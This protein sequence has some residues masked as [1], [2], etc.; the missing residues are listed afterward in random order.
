MRSLRVKILTT[1]ATLILASQISTVTAVLVTAN[2]DVSAR[3]ETNLLAGADLLSTTID[4]RAD[5]LAATV[6]ALASDFGFKQAVGTGETETVRSALQNHAERANADIAFIVDRNNRLLVTGVGNN[7]P[8]NMNEAEIARHGYTNSGRRVY[9]T[10]NA[11]YEILTVPVKAPLPIA[12]LSMGFKLDDAFARHLQKLTGLEVTLLGNSDAGQNVIAASNSKYSKSELLRAAQLIAGNTTTDTVDIDGHQHLA[13][14]H[15]FLDAHSEVGLLITKP[16]ADA[17]APYEL[18]KKASFALGALPLL[19]ALLGAVLLSRALTHPINRLMAAARRIQAGEYDVPVE[20]RSGDELREFGGAFNAMQSEISAREKRIVHQARHDTVTGLY[21]STYA[22]ELLSA[23][24]EAAKE[25]GNTVG[26]MV[27]GLGALDEI[28]SSLGHDLAS[29]YL[30]TIADRLQRF[31]GHDHILARMENDNFLIALTEH[32]SLR[33]RTVAE[34]LIAQLGTALKLESIKVNIKPAVGMALF[35]E[36]SSNADELLLR[37]TIARNEARLTGRS[38]RFYRKGDQEKRL[39]NMNLLQDLGRAT[40][41]NELQL[42]YQPKITLEDESVC[43]AEALVRWRHPD[44]G[45]L[46]PNEF[47]PL[48]E[49]SGNALILTRWVIGEACRQLAE[50]DR[51]GLNLNIAI[52]LSATDLLHDSLPW[53][54]MDAVKEH[55]LDPRNLIME[56]TEEAMV[57]DFQKANSTLERMHDLGLTIS[58]DD[59]GT[60]YSSLAQLKNLPAQELKI[61]R[62]FIAGVPADRADTAIVSAAINLA[63]ELGLKIVAEGVSDG[64]ALRWLRQHSVDRAQGF[65]WSK[66]LSANQF[67][68]WLGSFT[69][70]KTV[71]VKPLKL[72]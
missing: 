48:I 15:T 52:N 71:Q 17:M 25:Q 6:S 61:D 24:L 10:G 62:C 8:K 11:A 2:K 44:Y 14:L 21:N 34:E 1:T 23:A 54:V 64:A 35:P 67:E 20:I 49:S 57:E 12:W 3:A 30:T 13:I 18:L 46:L 72:V 59:F 47:M 26:L 27:I 22:L 68:Q 38:P 16:L 69:G 36:H 4:S 58:I 53:Y 50:W 41:Q 66:P 60:G 37:A 63:Q 31:A 43:G 19:A 7:Q 33:V 51:C 5:Q 29:A 28:T 55:R 45:W 32:G 70:G 9:V 65:Y 39:R 42:Y 40:E 56:V